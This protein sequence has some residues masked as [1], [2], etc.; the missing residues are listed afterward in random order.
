MASEI[1]QNSGDNRNQG[2]ARVVPRL[3]PDETT[4]Y[5]VVQR[6]ERIPGSEGLPSARLANPPSDIAEEVAIWSPRDNVSPQ[7]ENFTPSP[8][9]V[10]YQVISSVR[11]RGSGHTVFVI[12]VSLIITPGI[13]LRFVHGNNRVRLTDGT[14]VTVMVNC[15][16]PTSEA[17]AIAN[18]YGCIQGSRTPSQVAFQ[19]RGLIIT[20][21]SDL[22][23]E[24]VIEIARDIVIE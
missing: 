9:S 8:N 7:L 3:V 21:A 10:S 2:I 18:G 11:Y 17:E 24:R 16:S 1:A 13:S 4:D 19:R 12:T 22:P 23:I 6:D 14:P 15:D 20:V 5:V